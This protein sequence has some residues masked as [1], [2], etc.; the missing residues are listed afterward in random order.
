MDTIFTNSEKSKNSDPHGLLLSFS[1]K[2]DLK[3]SEKYLA[4]LNPSIY[5]T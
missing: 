5:Y 3:R 4:L 1:D 2:I